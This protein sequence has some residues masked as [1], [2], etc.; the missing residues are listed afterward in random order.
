MVTD[1]QN[2]HGSPAVTRLVDR[3]AGLALRTFNKTLYLDEPDFIDFQARSRVV[4]MAVVVLLPA[5]SGRAAQIVYLD[6]NP[7]ARF[8]FLPIDPASFDSGEIR[9]LGHGDPR[10]EAAREVRHHLGDKKESDPMRGHAAT[11]ASLARA[12]NPNELSPLE[13]SI[14]TRYVPA[15]ELAFLS[16]LWLWTGEPDDRRAMM[17]TDIRSVV[18]EQLS[19]TKASQGPLLLSKVC[20]LDLETGLRQLYG[21]LQQGDGLWT[22]SSSRL[23]DFMALGFLTS[24]NNDFAALTRKA[25]VFTTWIHEVTRVLVKGE[26]QK[27]ECPHDVEHLQMLLNPAANP[28]WLSSL[29]RHADALRSASEKKEP[30]SWAGALNSFLNAFISQT[31]RDEF[32][33]I[34]R[35]DGFPVYPLVHMTMLWGIESPLDWLAIPLGAMIKDGNAKSP[36]P[37]WPQ[38]GAFVL[39]LHREPASVMELVATLRPVLNTVAFIESSAWIEDVLRQ[40]HEQLENVIDEVVGHEKGAFTDAKDQHI[41]F[42]EQANGGT[43]FLDEIACLS[44]EMQQA[45][46][47]VVDCYKAGSDQS[48][49]RNKSHGSNPASK[50]DAMVPWRHGSLPSW[51]N[52][53]TLGP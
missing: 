13:R 30:L 31:E 27:E 9:P 28:D 18:L 50:I 53:S 29:T 36:H 23:Q 35:T 52:G 26:D 48:P 7:N 22:R 24:T 32:R 19:D 12:L 37:H 39:A 34:L 20:D 42:F 45:L 5:E 33:E 6:K 44:N 46:L 2:T 14:L 51:N 10:R 15:G 16:L 17:V 43:L 47:D 41:G 1:N 4:S 40:K 25:D 38:A 21:S 8:Q 11:L 3:L 49:H